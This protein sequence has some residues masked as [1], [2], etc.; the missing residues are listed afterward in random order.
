MPFLPADAIRIVVMVCMCLL[1][2]DWQNCQQDLTL[3]IMF[4]TSF[5][6]CT[7][8]RITSVTKTL[9]LENN[10]SY[11]CAVNHAPGGDDRA[12]RSSSQW[13]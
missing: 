10:K 1:G 13:M 2:S 12:R 6:L 9:L 3:D 4:L 7:P 11:K 8:G 5:E